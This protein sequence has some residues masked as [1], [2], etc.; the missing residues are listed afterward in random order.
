[1]KAWTFSSA[2]GMIQPFAHCHL[3]PLRNCNL[4]NF[5]KALFEDSRGKAWAFN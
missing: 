5:H 4:V 3:S 1:M 2:A